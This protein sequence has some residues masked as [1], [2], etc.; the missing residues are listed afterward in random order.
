MIT[1]IIGSIG[2]PIV[3]CVMLFNWIKDLEKQHKE[4]MTQ[5]MESINNNTQ[6]LTLLTDKI[7]DLDEHFKKGNTAN[8]YD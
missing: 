5:M 4:E 3:M 6:A 1:N 2:F 8:D 7:Q